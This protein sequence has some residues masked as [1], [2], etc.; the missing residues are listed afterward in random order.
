MKKLLSF[1]ISWMMLIPHAFSQNEVFTM[2]K[3]VNNTQEYFAGSYPGTVMMKVNL[4]GGVNRP[5]VYNVPINS[6]LT[7]V[8]TYAGGP[9]KEAEVDEVFVRSKKGDGYE[10]KKINLENFFKD[11]NEKPYRL[12]PDDY[13]YV[14]Q[15]EE[16]IDIN[17]YRVTLVVSTLVGVVLTGLLIDRTLQK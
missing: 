1:L 8:L 3:S 13:I 10:V 2:K 16:L 12:K 11:I 15:G 6:E 14:K 7:S 17:A 5:G 4:L 9:S